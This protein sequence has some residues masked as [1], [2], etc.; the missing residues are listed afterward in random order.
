MGARCGHDDG[1]YDQPGGRSGP[2]SMRIPGI[3]G[4]SRT[5]AI[6]SAPA[7][8]SS[9]KT[10]AVGAQKTSGANSSHTPTS[11][12]AHAAHGERRTTVT[13]ASRQMSAP[14]MMSLQARAVLR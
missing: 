4:M 1:L 2:G 10:A 6:T 7:S 8:V 9:A 5:N 11:A 14:L 3:P 13:V 12:F